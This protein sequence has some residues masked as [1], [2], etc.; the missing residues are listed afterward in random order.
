MKFCIG[1]M[2][3]SFTLN[4]TFRIPINGNMADKQTYV[5]G[6]TLAPLT[7]GPCNDARLQAFGK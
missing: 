4:H 5:L 6:S 3:I 1:V 7:M 2:L